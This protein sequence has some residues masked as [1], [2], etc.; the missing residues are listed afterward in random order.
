MQYEL[1]NL[2]KNNI[3][4]N[5]GSTHPEV[6]KEAV[7]EHRADYG[8]SLDGD[9]DRVILVDEKGNILDGD[10]LLYILAFANPNRTATTANKEVICLILNIISS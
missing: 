7:I 8:I 9:G 2:R 5:C 1:S 6:I 10:D 3:N 4:Q